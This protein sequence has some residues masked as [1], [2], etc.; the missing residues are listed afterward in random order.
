MK[1]NLNATPTMRACGR[2][3]RRVSTVLATPC[4]AQSSAENPVI[5]ADFKETF[6]I[7]TLILRT[8][9]FTILFFGRS[10]S[11]NNLQKVLA[12]HIT[13]TSPS[14]KDTLE[15]SPVRLNPLMPYLLPSPI[16]TR[17]C[18]I[19]CSKSP[20]VSG[21]TSCHIPPPHGGAGAKI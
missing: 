21:N 12:N 20:K 6:S 9:V 2:S 14:K 16:L 3:Y 1:S 8:R 17:P 13:R 18:A 7:S 19:T 4:R 5:Q 11:K 10:L 15:I